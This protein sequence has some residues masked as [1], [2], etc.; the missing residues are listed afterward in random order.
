MPHCLIEHAESIDGALL[1]PCV[2]AGALSSGLFEKGGGDIKVRSIP[3]DCYLSGNQGSDFVHVVLK[4]LSGRSLKDKQKLSNLV[5]NHLE[6]LSL[7]NCSITVEVIDI[8]KI[9][10]AKVVNK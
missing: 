8:E 10:Y 4:V 9:T 5:M 6:T 2:F 3:F 7:K 1:L